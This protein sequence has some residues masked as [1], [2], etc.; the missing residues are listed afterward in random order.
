MPPNTLSPGPE[1]QCP[2]V[3]SVARVGDWWSILIL[4]D[5]CYGLSRFDEFQ[6]SLGIAPTMLTRR[7][8]ALV[9]DGLLQRW[10]YSERPP[11]NEYVL[12]ESGRDFQ[13]V[14]WSLLAW[15]NK[16]F[17]PEGESVVVIDAETGERADPVLVDRAT[18]RPLARPAFRT[19]A[20]PAANPR[21]RTRYA[22]K[23][24]NP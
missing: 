14:I 10:R 19:A 23:G 11:R 22:Q 4:R 16:H 15:G 3:R 2:I 7:L 9:K 6:K 5:A 1:Q 21:I 20:G 12:T 17:A 13:P 24:A 18:G 8:A